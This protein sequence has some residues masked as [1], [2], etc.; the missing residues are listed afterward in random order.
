MDDLHLMRH[1]AFEAAGKY[2]AAHSEFFNSLA[3]GNNEQTTKAA[4]KAHTIAAVYKRALETLITYLTE[5]GLSTVHREEILRTMQTVDI[6]E[7]ETKMLAAYQQSEAV[8]PVAAETA[9][10]KH[11]N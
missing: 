3:R 11:F 4:L 10:P 7:K 2:H 8:G 5:A 1:Y 6:L 9:T